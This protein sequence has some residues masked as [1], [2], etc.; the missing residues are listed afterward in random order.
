FNPELS[1]EENVY[2][3]GLIWGYSPREI[4]AIMKEVFS[5]ASLTDFTRVPLKN[6]SSGMIMRLG[7][8]LATARRPDVLLVDEALAVG[9]ASFQQKCLNRFEEFRKA[10][11]ATIIVSHDLNLLKVVSTRILVIERGKVLFDGEPS[12]ALSNYM[13]VIAENSFGEASGNK[14]FLDN[15]FIEDFSVTMNY[16]G[17]QNPPVLPVASEIFLKI[18]AKAKKNIPD[19]TIGFHID[20]SRGVRVFGS[21]SFHLGQEIKEV[22]TGSEVEATFRFP[23]NLSFGKYTLGISLHEGDNHSLN[24]YLW[25]DSVLN[26]ELERVNVPK[27]DGIAYL[28]VSVNVSK[29]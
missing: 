25:E 26:F 23:L 8:A 20:D 7:F 3:N 10:G 14:P 5:F 29:K 6:Y 21:N 27:F 19:L 9:D 16:N 17:M 15:A 2:Y 11:T 18:K 1:G 4:G 28:P 13:R 22:V 24:C 12:L